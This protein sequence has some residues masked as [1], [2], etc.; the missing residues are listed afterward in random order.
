MLYIVYSVAEDIVATKVKYRL[1]FLD[2]DGTHLPQ[3]LLASIGVS[4]PVYTIACLRSCRGE[5]EIGSVKKS[6]G[7]HVGILTCH[8]EYVKMNERTL[9]R[10][11]CGR[12]RKSFVA[13]LFET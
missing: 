11:A 3:V 8:G 1:D 9:G 12:T 13:T 6:E 10:R 7:Q 4:H 5:F 2:D